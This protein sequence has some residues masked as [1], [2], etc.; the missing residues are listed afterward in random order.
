MEPLRVIY[1]GIVVFKIHHDVCHD[2]VDSQLHTNTPPNFARQDHPFGSLGHYPFSKLHNR[3][4]KSC[5][6]TQDNWGPRAHT[7]KSREELRCGGNFI[8]A[9]S[10]LERAARAIS[11]NLADP[12]RKR[13]PVRSC[14]RLCPECTYGNLPGHEGSGHISD[15]RECAGGATVFTGARI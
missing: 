10:D 2:R 8:V 14:G 15:S 12:G 9:A 13:N 1:R 5:I 4:W 11:G 6:R 7:L 3:Q